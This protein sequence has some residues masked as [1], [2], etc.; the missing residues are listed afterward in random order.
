MTGLAS[1]ELTPIAAIEFA[2]AT[3]QASPVA[4]LF[5]HVAVAS[6]ITLFVKEVG[7]SL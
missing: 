2:S 3:V 1:P 6:S 7:V 5:V 4:G